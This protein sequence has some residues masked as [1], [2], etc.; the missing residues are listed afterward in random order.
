MMIR[1]SLSML[2]MLT[3]FAGQTLAAEK[4]LP[5]VHQDDFE[6]GVD[7]WEPTDAK[8]WKVKK[9][10]KG[11]V[12]SQYKNSK[13][14][15]PHRSPL[16]I[17]LVKDASVGDFVLTTKVL[18]THKDYGHRDCCLFFGYQDSGHFYYVHLGKKTDN[19]AN[20]IF[21]VNG[22]ARKK[23]SLKTTKGTNWDTKWH[24][25]K[26]VR[27]VD[28]GTIE[29]YYDDMKTPVMIAKDKTFVWGRVGLGSFD[30]TGDWDDFVLRGTKAAAKK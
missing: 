15:P 4:E 28:D 19:H 25:V 29:I 8:A 2:L 6:K 9:T 21:I 24:N 10:D 12:Y 30:D 7:N 16:N 5:I 17:S 26:I 13:Y 11:N 20:Q 27:K 22:K 1:L 18:S 3:C 23:I 14:R